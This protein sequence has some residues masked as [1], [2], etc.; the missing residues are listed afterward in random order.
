M[1]E[2]SASLDKW[3]ELAETT[4]LGWPQWKAEIE[5]GATRWHILGWSK[6]EGFFVRWIAVC[7]VDLICWLHSLTDHEAEA[8]FENH[9][10]RKLEEWLR[11]VRGEHYDYAAALQANVLA[12]H[13][14]GKDAKAE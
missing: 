12:A 11:V 10:R 3:R 9:A 1:A 2:K 4:D 5:P 8:L 6:K 14:E 7:A 13:K